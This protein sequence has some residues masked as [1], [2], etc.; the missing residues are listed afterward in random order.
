MLNG[1][2]ASEKMRATAYFPLETWVKVRITRN[3]AGI[4]TVY[5]DGVEIVETSGSNPFTDTTYKNS[6]YLTIDMG[7]GDKI[8]FIDDA[9]G[10]RYGV[11]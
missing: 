1:S 3:Y 10:V 11:S 2:S 9:P 7:N 5:S 4:F 8:A 6:S